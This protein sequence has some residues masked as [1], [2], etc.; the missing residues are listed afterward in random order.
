[1]SCFLPKSSVTHSLVGQCCLRS[2]CFARTL[3]AMMLIQEK[4]NGMCISPFPTDPS[5]S[6]PCHADSFIQLKQPQQMC[7]CPSRNAFSRNDSELAVSYTA[8][9]SYCRRAVEL[10]CKDPFLSL[11]KELEGETAAGGRCLSSC[12]PLLQWEA[13]GSAGSSSRNCR[14]LSWTEMP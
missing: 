12:S 7:L 10:T 11:W 8:K 14:M 6:C 3:L 5:G 2:C 1:M 9:K 13:W 4:G